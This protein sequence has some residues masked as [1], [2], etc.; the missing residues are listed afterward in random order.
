[1]P[2]VIPSLSIAVPG[3]PGHQFSDITIDDADG[4]TVDLHRTT[5]RHIYRATGLIGVTPPRQVVRPR[6]SAHG[7]INDTRNT[8]GRLI[9][10]EG[11]L[12]G[13]QSATDMF[14]EFYAV[15]GALLETLDYGEAWLKWTIDGGPSMQAL[16]KLHGELEPPVEVG[17]NILA[18]QVQVLAQDPRAYSQTL[19][20]STGGTLTSSPGGWAWPETPPIT[21][22]L[23][24]GGTTA[25][26][27][28]GNRPTPPVFRVYGACVNPQILLLGTSSRIALTGTVSAGDYLEIDVQNRSITI[29]GTSPALNFLDPANTTW[30][31]LPRGTSTIQLLAPTFDTVAR[32]DVL[33]RSAFT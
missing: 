2:F 4:N 6:P 22:S 24:A 19:S 9:V 1:M 29:N 26:S 12:L 30:F 28:D 25:V 31:E 13:E 27:N 20:T 32:V 14:S 7:F 33:Y 21:F 11:R 18:Y 10:L 16:V 17:P 3:T 8:E 15:A 5:A 23:S